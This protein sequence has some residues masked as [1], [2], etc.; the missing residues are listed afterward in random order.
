MFNFTTTT[1][2]NNNEYLDGSE[3][4]EVKRDVSGN[5]M[6]QVKGVGNFYLNDQHTELPGGV[7][8][9]TRKTY[10][11]PVKATADINLGTAI[12]AAGNYMLEIYVRLTQDSQ[13]SLYA[14]DMAYKGRRFLYEFKVETGDLATIGTVVEKIIKS[15]GVKFQDYTYFTTSSTA[16]NLK[17]TAKDEYTFFSEVKLS[18]YNATLVEYAEV[19]VTMTKT[20]AKSGFGTYKYLSENIMIPNYNWVTPGGLLQNELPI[21]GTNYD[22]YVIKFQHTRPAL[23]GANAV[24]EQ[25]KSVTTH[26][27]YVAN[28]GA[29]S[30]KTTPSPAP[31][32]ISL[33]FKHAVEG[34][35]PVVDVA[36][37]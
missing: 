36:K 11:L 19:P 8:S 12:T 14:N 10:S 6:L 29:A 25:V 34:L 30:T 31:V 27:F 9:A 13:N 20:N 28:S 1:I 26:V 22:Q 23:G 18:K 15:I 35:L 4:F 17:L 16:T 2:I 21:R 3:I 33:D 7:I 32:G 37:Y 5:A 24:G